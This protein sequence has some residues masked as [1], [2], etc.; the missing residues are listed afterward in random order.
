MTF[1][2]G[3]KVIYPNHGLGIIERIEEEDH[4]RH[5][6][7]I[8]FAPHRLERDDGACAGRERRQRRTAPRDWRHRSRSP[9]PNPRRRQD[10][11]P[12]EL[13]GRTIQGQL[14]E[15]MRSGSIYD[16]A[17]VLK[18]LSASEQVEEPVFREKRKLTGARFLVVRRFPRRS[19]KA[20]SPSRSRVDRALT[21][22]S[23]PSRRV[24]EGEGRQGPALPVPAAARRAVAPLADRVHFAPAFEGWGSPSGPGLRLS[25]DRCPLPP[26][27]GTARPLRRIPLCRP[28]AGV[29]LVVAA[30]SGRSPPTSPSVYVLLVGPPPCFSRGSS[31]GPACSSSSSRTVAWDWPGAL[32]ITSRLGAS[33]GFAKGRAAVYC[34][35]PPAT[36]YAPL[37]FHVLHPRLHTLDKAEFG[38]MPILGSAAPIAGFIPWSGRI[39]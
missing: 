5:D 23:S 18:S 20:R 29:A 35:N 19:R 7:R 6:V 36:S 24:R 8:L 12:A 28:F 32:G 27:I 25:R 39:T 37:L 33:S 16:V 2:I 4:S 3:D 11:Q 14:G 30:A 13:E 9:V 31:S 17:D 10:R 38:K 22:R 1:Q 26:T 34:A 21:A 15:K